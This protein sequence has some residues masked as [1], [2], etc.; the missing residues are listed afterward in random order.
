M[1][2]RITWIDGLR[3]IAC[4]GVFI[5]H[6]FLSFYP[7]VFFGEESVSHVSGKLD[8]KLGQNPISTFFCGE[9]MVCIFLLVSGLVVSYQM[10]QIEEKEKVSDFILKRYPKL[11]LPL[12]CV[13]LLVW[14]MLHLGIFSNIG[15]SKMTGSVWLGDYYQGTQTLRDVVVCSFLLVW[16]VMDN[17]F[18]NVFWMLK[19]L[20]FGSILSALLGQMAWGKNKKMYIVYGVAAVISFQFQNMYLLFVM[21]SFLSYFMIQNHKLKHQKIWGG[22]CLLLGLFFGGFPTKVI[23]NGIY[24]VFIP[25][26]SGKINAQFLHMIAAFFTLIG[27]YYLEWIQKLLNRKSCQ[28]MGKISYSFFL[29][30]I[31]IMFSFSTWL[32][33]II[34]NL[35][36]QYFFASL[37]V[38]LISFI[39][40]TGF[41]YCFYRFIEKPCY[42]LIDFAISKLSVKSVIKGA[43]NNE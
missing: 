23:P 5:H 7:G 38:V 14:G 18:S 40:T 2:K 39:V 6:F 11:S 31:P 8:Y 1:T 30:H 4:I 17:R 3:G 9:Y 37:V 42:R 43:T 10:Q 29:L 19:I 20:F 41:S 24:E 21:G 26:M 25:I 34:L 16:F 15:I 28:F 12:F 27:I 13:S 33:G 32:F 36:N 35:T 22:L